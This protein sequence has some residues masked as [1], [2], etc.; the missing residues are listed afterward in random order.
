MKLKTKRRSRVVQDRLV[1]IGIAAE[2][3]ND[4]ENTTEI[5]R[6]VDTVLRILEEIDAD[7]V[8]GYKVDFDDPVMAKLFVKNKIT[9]DRPQGPSGQ[10][11]GN[12]VGPKFEEFFSAVERAGE[13][14][15][16]K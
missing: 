15:D 14:L 16:R 1:C 12:C 11:Y 7:R 13:E 10:P 8:Y 6:P 9:T 3:I 5:W 2:T 4:G